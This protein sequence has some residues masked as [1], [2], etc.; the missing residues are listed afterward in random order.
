ML[1]MIKLP[2]FWYALAVLL[3][4]AVAVFGGKHTLKKYITNSDSERKKKN[5]KDHA[6]N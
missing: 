5:D 3:I 4:A 6:E 1:E 2:D